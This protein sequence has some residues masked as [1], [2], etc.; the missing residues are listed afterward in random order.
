MSLTFKNIKLGVKGPNDE[1]LYLKDVVV[2]GGN[3]S[4]QLS[5]D[6][7]VWQNK[8]VIPVLSALKQAEPETNFLVL[9]GDE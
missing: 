4:Y 8:D 9:N 2:G 5:A 6:G 3:V 7:Q 1:I